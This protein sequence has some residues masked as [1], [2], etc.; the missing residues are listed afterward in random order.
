MVKNCRLSSNALKIIAMLSMLV[1][2]TGFV[3]FPGQL[4]FRYVGRIAF[5]I[6]CFL[7]TEGFF[8][9]RNVY[10][11][12][13][14]MGVFALIS[15]IPFNLGLYHTLVYRWNVN[16]FFTLF[17]GLAVMYF[18]EFMYRRTGSRSPGILFCFM[19]MM[20]AEYI[21]S[22]YGSMGVLVIYIFYLA[23]E[24]RNCGTVQSRR[25]TTLVMCLAEAALFAVKSSLERW[26]VFSLIPILLYSGKKSGKIWKTLHMDRIDLFIKYFF[27]AV[28]PFHL[29]VLWFIYHLK[30]I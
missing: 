4:M 28:Y 11:Y 22:D 17:L 6:Y 9:T 3:F 30:H 25:N 16:V 19:G 23:Y 27:Y 5:P 1:D 14:R 10:R 15:E 26:A 2:H 21:H 18:S 8:H 7:L 29:L 24:G 13:A 12:M 20:A